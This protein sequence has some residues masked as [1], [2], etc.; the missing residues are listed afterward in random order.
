MTATFDDAVEFIS[1][2]GLAYLFGSKRATEFPNLHMQLTGHDSI[3]DWGP[4]T[5]VVWECRAELPLR[6]A[7]WFGEWLRKRGTFVSVGL[8]P[9]AL[10]WCGRAAD[11]EE[12]VSQA[13]GI[14]PDAGMVY[15][16]V[17]AEGPIASMALRRA[18]GL[19]KSESAKAFQNA[20][21]SLQ[22]GLFVTTFGHEQESGAW[23]S[24]VYE[25]TVRAFPDVQILDQTAGL[26][27]L[28]SCLREQADDPSPRLAATLFRAPVELVREVWD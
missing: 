19:E 12:D 13:W 28:V 6:G 9:A 1:K 22:H 3:D 27:E 25:P 24:S 17:L 15:E 21:K 23:A 14:S 8:L 7:A 16:A 4:E 10:G 11:V 5:E 26:H 2:V 18:V 20:L